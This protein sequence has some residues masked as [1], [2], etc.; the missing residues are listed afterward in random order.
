MYKFIAFISML[1]RQFVLPNPF[2]PLSKAF[3]SNIDP[4]IISIALYAINLI[5]EPLL[6]F[7]TFSIV[8]M[9]YKRKLNP[10]FIGSFLYLFFYIIHTFILL[11]MSYAKFSSWAVILLIVLYIGGHIAINVYMHSDRSF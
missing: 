10:P 5:A 11:F 6:Y 9:Y 3:G 7:F 4:F 8:G 1:V 2:E